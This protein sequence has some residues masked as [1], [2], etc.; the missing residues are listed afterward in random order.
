MNPQWAAPH[1]GFQPQHQP[2]YVPQAPQQPPYG[3]YGPPQAPSGVYLPHQP[4]YAYDAVP[5][6][7][8]N[9]ALGG[10]DGD[11]GGMG[12]V[13][14]DSILLQGLQS[15]FPEDVTKVLADTT[16]DEEG[17][18]EGKQLSIYMPSLCTLSLRRLM[19]S[20]E[21]GCVLDIARSVH[22][23]RKD[24]APDTAQVTNSELI[25]LLLLLLVGEGGILLTTCPSWSTKYE[26]K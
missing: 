22:A 25:L 17:I 21:V 9:A 15:R 2:Q 7:S 12:D 23:R 24:V 26:C 14:P 6:G 20:L 4:Q 18:L 11:G 10:Q 16:L 3:V 8:Q 1:I 19:W 5:A 13:D